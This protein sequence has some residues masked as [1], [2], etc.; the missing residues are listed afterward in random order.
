LALALARRLDGFDLLDELA[1]R[2]STADPE[3][4]AA[5]GSNRFPPSPIRLA[6][7]PLIVVSAGRIR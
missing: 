7:E 4:L 1:E 2:F 3:K 6:P 5:F